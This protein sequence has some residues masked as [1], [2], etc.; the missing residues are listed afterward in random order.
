MRLSRAT[1]Q[2]L[3]ISSDKGRF[4]ERGEYYSTVC[5]IALEG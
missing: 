4:S 3:R 1:S 5:L 2:L